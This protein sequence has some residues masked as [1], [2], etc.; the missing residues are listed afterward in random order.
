MQRP[1]RPS[2]RAFSLV[3]LAVVVALLG[4]M[5]ASVTPALRGVSD[6]RQSAAWREAERRLVHAR[7]RAMSTGRAFGVRI[8]AAS[9]TFELLEIP[10]GGGIP[11]GARDALGQT[12]PAWSLP[13]AYPSTA[14]S[15]F[16]GGDGVSGTGVVWFGHDGAPQR[17]NSSGA[18][19]GAF[20]QDAVV[21]LT[22]GRTVTVREV[23]GLVER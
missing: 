6:A 12:I 19:L 23:S 5:A 9:G 16:V 17:R 2:S 22:G 20:T 15:S 14:V 21:T 1:R 18:L 3:E 13:T 11:Q 10:V 8:T 7:T 4:I